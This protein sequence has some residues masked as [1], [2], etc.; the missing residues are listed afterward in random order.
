M[1]VLH[2]LA[3]HLPLQSGYSMRSSAII[4]FQQKM[5]LEPVVFTLPDFNESQG[6]QFK[7]RETCDG[8]VVYNWVSP[9][10]H[11]FEAFMANVP[12]FRN[13]YDSRRKIRFYLGLSAEAAPDI[14]H[15]HSPA[16]CA[17]FA[18]L[19]ARKRAVPFVYEIRGLWE[20]TAVAE[21][22]FERSSVEFQR[23]SGLETV[24]AKACHALVVIS[25]G[26]KKEF[27]SR[28]VPEE[29]I[30]VVPNGVNPRE[31]SAA[32]MDED[33]KIKLGLQGRPVFGYIGAVRHLEG[34]MLAVEAMPEILKS[35][36]D[37]ALLIVGGGNERS[38]LKAAA[39][40]L[41][42]LDKSVFIKDEVPHEHIPA[43]YSAIDLF[44][45]PRMDQRV[46]HFVT[47]L[48][49]L[50]AMAMGKAVLASDTG[51]LKEQIED[52]KT[53][54]LFHA[55]DL[56]DFTAKTVSLLQDKGR[57]DRYGAAGRAWVEKERD[58][59]QITQRYA[60][61]YSYAMKKYKAMSR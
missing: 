9:K 1:K 36:P 23:R 33:F 26:L 44:I 10:L 39:E 47:P 27:I 2:F 51:G 24:A 58:W 42:L 56:A 55:E 4:S 41:G 43:F 21:G 34:L 5:G 60:E 59:A 31:F 46:C 57:R 50:E 20:E 17:I 45:L 19:V 52:G 12:F 40:R 15:A 13:I 32:R 8:V 25:E 6:F 7:L 38:S 54:E 22:K 18:D 53:G 49:P 48:K 30:F 16:T 3:T 35:I 29:K 28:G 37:A 11:G 61:V 14:V